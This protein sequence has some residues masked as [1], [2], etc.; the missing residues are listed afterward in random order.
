M[1]K[2]RALSN[3]KEDVHGDTLSMDSSKIG[4]F[5]ERNEISLSGFLK[6]HDGGGL[7]TE[8][9]LHA[10]HHKQWPRRQRIRTYLEILRDFTDETLEGEL[11]DK[12]L[13]RLLV[14]T[15][16]TEGD[17]SGAE[18]MGLLDT[19]GGVLVCVTK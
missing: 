18:T 4:V 2:T 10:T 19:T 8:I 6:S 13:G 16:F 12:E 14:T 5:E 17:G 7:E 11:P 9:G 1:S 15:D 3:N